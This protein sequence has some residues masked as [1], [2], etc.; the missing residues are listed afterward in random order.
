MLV[1]CQ[2]RFFAIVIGSESMTGEINKGDVVVCEKYDGDEL[3]ENQIIVFENNGVRV[4]HRIVEIEHV[5]GELRIYTKGDANDNEDNGYRTP[6]DVF[7]VVHLKISYI[8]YP[9]LWVREIFS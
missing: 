7:G 5:D 3:F 1:S 8:G 4:V 6:E 9:T 2:F